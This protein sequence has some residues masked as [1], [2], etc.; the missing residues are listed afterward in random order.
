MTA[1]QRIEGL[2]TRLGRTALRAKIGSDETE[3]DGFGGSKVEDD[4]E[5]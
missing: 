3:S 4:N 2:L 5:V 1:S